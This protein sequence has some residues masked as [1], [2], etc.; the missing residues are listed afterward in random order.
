MDRTNGYS[1]AISGCETGLIAGSR[2][3]GSASKPSPS[4]SESTPETNSNLPDG[5]LNPWSTY[6]LS[7]GFLKSGTNIPAGCFLSSATDRTLGSSIQSRHASNPDS[8]RSSPRPSS[9]LSCAMMSTSER[10]CPTG[11]IAGC[12]SIT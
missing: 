2:K 6:F 10:D 7:A 4:I 12:E 11:S 5:V 9:L 3:E 1:L 8:S